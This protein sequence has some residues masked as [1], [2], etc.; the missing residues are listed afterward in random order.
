M[1]VH[2]GGK[3]GKAGKLWHPKVLPRPQK[4]KQERLW[5]TTKQNPTD[6]KEPVQLHRLL[7]TYQRG[8]FI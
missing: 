6:G 4:A 5:Q 1:A 8:F 7:F 3:V 2:H